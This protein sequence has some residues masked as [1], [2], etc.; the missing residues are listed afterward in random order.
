MERNEV[1]SKLKTIIANELNIDE[2]QI[3][4]DSKLKDE[5]Y[6]DSLDMIEIILKVEDEFEIEI[7]DNEWEELE[8]LSKATDLVISKLGKSDK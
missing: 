6:A 1:E 2:S 4:S 3:K 7:Y 5:F 8:T